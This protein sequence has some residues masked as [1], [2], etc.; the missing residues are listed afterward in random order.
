MKNQSFF[1]ISQIVTLR[2]IKKLSSFY[3]NVKIK[4]VNINIEI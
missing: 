3:C 1:T 2:Q 4:K